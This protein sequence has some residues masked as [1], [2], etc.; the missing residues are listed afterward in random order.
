MRH[1]LVAQT[2]HHAVSAAKTLGWQNSEW[3]YVHEPSRLH[4]LNRKSTIYAEDSVYR[5][6][7]WPE[8]LE[9]IRARDLNI[10]W[11]E[12]ERAP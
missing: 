1:L 8:F 6:R 3:V 11:I 4:G 2:H 12:S 7:D 9:I 10:R 5:R